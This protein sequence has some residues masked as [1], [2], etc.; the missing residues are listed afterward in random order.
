MTKISKENLPLG[1][2]FCIR[3][4]MAEDERGRFI[5]MADADFLAELGF[6]TRE[7]FYS[8]N[9]KNTLRGL[10]Y[11]KPSPQARIVFCTKGR[12]WDVIVDIRKSSPTFGRWHAL[13]LSE[14]NGLG[15]FV[16]KGFAH[17]FLTLEDGSGALYL[18]D[19]THS[20]ESDMGIVF[21]DP[22]LNIAWPLSGGKPIVSK[23]DLSFPMLKDALL[24]E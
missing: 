6:E 18:A 2:A 19:E 10:H 12:I 3:P 21:N 5:K 11:L 7:M 23:R 1:G 9:R 4:F 15:V 17:G 14:K 8:V 13:E 16:P 20:P 22:E 24:Y